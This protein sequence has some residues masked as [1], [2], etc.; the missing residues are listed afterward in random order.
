MITAVEAI[1]CLIVARQNNPDTNEA[2]QY[3]R[4]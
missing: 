1:D 3:E 2:Y 4:H